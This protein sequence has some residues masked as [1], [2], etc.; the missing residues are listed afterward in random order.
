MKELLV[1][2]YTPMLI[3]HSSES[4]Q[5]IVTVDHYRMPKNTTKTVFRF[6]RFKLKHGDCRNKDSEEEILHWMVKKNN[7]N[8]RTN[9]V[10]L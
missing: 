5:P 8:N 9:D 10:A 4:Q 1:T 6:H 2:V 3:L 7:K